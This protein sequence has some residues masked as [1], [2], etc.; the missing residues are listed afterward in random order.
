MSLRD[1]IAVLIRRLVQST[2]TPVH[3]LCVPVDLVPLYILSIRQSPAVVA[4]V[5]AAD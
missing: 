5:S 4:L 2:M 3:L 1:F